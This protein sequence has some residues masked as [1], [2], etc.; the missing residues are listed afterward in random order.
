MFF[1]LFRFATFTLV[2][3][4]G[5]QK[6]PDE[7]RLGAVVR[8]AVEFQEVINL[9]GNLR[10]NNHAVVVQLVAHGHENAGCALA[11]NT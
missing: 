6:R 9:L 5:Y 11:V 10:C 4:P 1:G 2:V 8:T 7:P 3:S